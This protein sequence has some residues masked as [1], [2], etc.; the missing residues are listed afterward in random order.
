[1]MLVTEIFVLDIV[2][3]FKHGLLHDVSVG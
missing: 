3:G 1:L 2:S